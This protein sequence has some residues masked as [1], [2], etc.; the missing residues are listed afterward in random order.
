MPSRHRRIGL[1]VDEDV[2]AAL[3]LVRDAS[4]EGSLPDATAVRD[5]VFE[6]AVLS[7][8][9]SVARQPSTEV[10]AE[11]A[12]LLARIRVLLPALELPA[13]V[14]EAVGQSVDAAHAGRLSAER[15]QKQRVLLSS[16][17]PHG[18]AALD[19]AATYD[20]LDAVSEVPPQ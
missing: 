15:R 4:T 3:S 8:L 5:A 11:A 19:Y 1:V 14:T 2:D 6:G 17:N 9:V 13:S 20:A 10:G 16:P 7:A 18:P 12:A